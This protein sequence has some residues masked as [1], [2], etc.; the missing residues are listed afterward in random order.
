MVPIHRVTSEAG[1][2][3]SVAACVCVYVCVWRL[4]L[5][6][7]CVCARI[8]MRMC[9]CACVSLTSALLWS[10]FNHMVGKS[11]RL[12][13]VLSA[14]INRPDRVPVC[15]PPPLRFEG[16]EGVQALSDFW[17]GADRSVVVGFF[18][19]ISKGGWRKKKKMSSKLTWMQ[20][21]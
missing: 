2:E 8:C 12:V 1:L 21:N 14:S 20:L 4:V 7:V 15:P 10:M 11:Q 16:D 3:I 9:A 6:C 5:V 19:S 18:L 17:N 13:G